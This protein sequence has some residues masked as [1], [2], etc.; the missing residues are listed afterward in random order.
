MNDQWVSFPRIKRATV[1]RD[2]IADE[3]RH[4]LDFNRRGLVR[5]GGL[6]A[7]GLGLGDYFRIQRIAAAG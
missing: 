5:V 2:L 7:L 4:R 6:T 3:S 1:L